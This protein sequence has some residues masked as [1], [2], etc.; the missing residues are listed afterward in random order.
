MTVDGEQLNDLHKVLD[1][2]RAMVAAEDLDQLLEL[3]VDRSMELLRAER[4]TVFLYDAQR[5][6]LVSRVAAGADE[7]RFPADRGIAGEAVSK[8]ATINVPDAYADKRFNPEVDRKTGFRTRNILSVPLQGHNADMVG[9]LQVLNKADGPFADY[10]V[11][12]AETLAA[13]AGVALQRASLLE[14]YLQKQQMQ[15]AMAIA[16][17]IQQDLLPEGSPHACGF[18]IAGAANPADETGGDVY[19]FMLTPDGRWAMIVA[20]AT[21]HGIGPAMVIAETRAMLRAVS[22][23]GEDIPAIMRTVNDLLIADLDD[24]LFVTC[25]FGLLD[26]ITASMDYSSAGH[27]PIIFYDRSKDD[28]SVSAATDLPLGVMEQMPYDRLV[29]LKFQPGD[30]V[31]VTTDGF[32]EAAD[33]SGEQF[34]IDRITEILRRDRDLP[35]EDMVRKLHEATTQFVGSEPQADDLTA[36]AI[37][38][39]Y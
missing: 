18:D 28:F 10:D 37:R 15:R 13:Q 11:T 34:G 8:A 27:G 5:N 16:R 4:A 12:L 30:F 33:A 32:Y 6:E 9:V 26:P 23:H 21:G 38:R 31:V 2:S 7:I 20:D 25:F 1:I 24:G 29:T 19:D 17:D 22:M 35:A 39:R 36:I 3:I 14:H